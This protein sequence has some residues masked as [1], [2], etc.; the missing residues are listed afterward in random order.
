MA[1]PTAGWLKAAGDLP[2][3]TLLVLMLSGVLFLERQD[4][5]E[6][7]T[8]IA[9]AATLNAETAQQVKEYAELDSVSQERT[10]AA[11]EQLAE[12][13]QRMIEIQVER[14][15]IRREQVAATR[16]LAEAMASCLGLENR[17]SRGRGG[18]TLDPGRIARW[19]GVK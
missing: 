11:M 12:I 4:R 13:D 1:M 16:K 7:F 5:R 6:L 2:I 3:A 10:A 17:G 14:V 15:E 18:M 8:K 19:P 9:E